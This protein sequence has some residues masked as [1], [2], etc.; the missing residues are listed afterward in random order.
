M[1]EKKMNKG[2]EV[3]NATFKVIKTMSNEEYK[4]LYDKLNNAYKNSIN[5]TCQIRE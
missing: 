3:L 1:R 2:T 4:K 5:S